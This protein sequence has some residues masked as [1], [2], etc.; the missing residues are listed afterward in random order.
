MYPNPEEERNLT[1]KRKRQ[2][3]I[4]NYTS[5]GNQPPPVT[6]PGHQMTFVDDDMI[7]GPVDDLE[8]TGSEVEFSVQEP[9]GA[10]IG[11]LTLFWD[12]RSH[13]YWVNNIRVKR[14]YQKKGIGTRL[15]R[16]AAD[17]HG[18]TIYFSNQQVSEDTSEDT[19]S[20][21]TEAGALATSALRN[22]VNVVVTHP[23]SLNFG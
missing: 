17:E 15:L 22:G 4:L 18:G 10:T 21:S 8:F 12:D 16:M 9:S 23:S 19:R 5:V 6:Q 3:S 7:A 11:E 14:A 20:M 2:S 13:T 1:K